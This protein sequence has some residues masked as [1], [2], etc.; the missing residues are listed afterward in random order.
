[1]IQQKIQLYIGRGKANTA[2]KDLG[3]D[4]SSVHFMCFSTFFFR[5]ENPN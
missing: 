4:N 1:M 5:F 2:K 3:D